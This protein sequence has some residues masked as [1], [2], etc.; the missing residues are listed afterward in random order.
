MVREQSEEEEVVLKKIPTK[1]VEKRAPKARKFNELQN[2]KID[3]SHVRSTM[4]TGTRRPTLR[5]KNLNRS[6]TIRSALDSE[7]APSTTRPMKKS[8]KKKISPRGRNDTSTLN[9]V[10]ETISK[11]SPRL[12]RK[13][14]KKK[15][16]G[17]KSPY[18]SSNRID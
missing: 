10:E 5:I 8:K 3:L 6:P 1:P 12:R 14:G 16:T 9:S 2:K 18:M 7:V 11:L 17:R 4:D 13:S 15:P